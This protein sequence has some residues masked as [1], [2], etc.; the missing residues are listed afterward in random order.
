IGL[1]A[2]GHLIEDLKGR[3]KV[4]ESVLKYLESVKKD[5]LENIGRW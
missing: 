2:V 5:I 4:N 1:F 3:Y